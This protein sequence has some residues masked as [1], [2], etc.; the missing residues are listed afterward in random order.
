MFNNGLYN[1]CA[2]ACVRMCVCDGL[3]YGYIYEVNLRWP[4]GIGN[5]LKLTPKLLVISYNT[6]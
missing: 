3:H 4:Y 5:W 6:K 1:V 2:R